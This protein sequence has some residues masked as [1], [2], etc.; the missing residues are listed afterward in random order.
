M[1]GRT[2]LLLVFV[3][4][5]AA[6]QFGVPDQNGSGNRVRVHLAFASGRC[7]T[8]TKVELMQST[9]S[10]ARGIADKSCMVEFLAVPPGVYRLVISGRGFMGIETGEITLTSFDNEPIEVSIPTSEGQDNAALHPAS[11]SVS[12]L[13]IPKR[14]AKKFDNANREMERQ[15]WGAA[16]DSLKQAIAIYP[17]YAAAYNNLGVVY[18]REGDRGREADALHRAITIDSSYV[19]AYVNLGRMDIAEEDFTDAEAELKRANALEP[20]DGVIWVLLSY[21]EY[22][23]HQLDDAVNAC[24]R[25]HQLNTVPHAF[26]HWTAAFA[27]EAKNQIAEAGAE[28]STFVSEEPTGQRADAARK[29]LANIAQFLSGK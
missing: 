4:I 18:A 12:D 28:F 21:A 3:V 17:R 19:P 13:G 2:L 11:T 20:E 14:A 26:A 5:P 7:D 9:S 24:R 25:V 6:A 27:L 29:E 15:E 16:A 10:V 23:N 22:M 8:S 1:L